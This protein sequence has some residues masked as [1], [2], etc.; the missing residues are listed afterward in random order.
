MKLPLKYF[1]IDY[2]IIFLLLL[3]GGSVPFVFFRNPITLFLLGIILLFLFLNKNNI[4]RKTF[5]SG[6]SSI[7]FVLIFLIINFFFASSGQSLVKFGYLFISFLI[8]IFL[9]I[10][11]DTRRISLVYILKFILQI[12][13]I[14]SLINFFIL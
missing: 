7:V 14:H 2:L 13:M 1:N 3:T 12:I 11:I 8:P 9:I 6:I 4:S 10:Y 5:N